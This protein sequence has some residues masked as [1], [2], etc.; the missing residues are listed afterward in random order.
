DI[1]ANEL[2]GNL[3]GRVEAHCHVRNA[4]NGAE[5]GSGAAG[6]GDG[7]AA[8]GKP[9]AGHFFKASLGGDGKRDG[10]HFGHSASR[11]STQRAQP[12]AAIGALAPR[13]SSRRSYWPPEA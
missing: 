6:A 11:R 7:K 9:V 2:A 13:R 5:I 1:A 4:I 10:G 3:G 12:E 8:L